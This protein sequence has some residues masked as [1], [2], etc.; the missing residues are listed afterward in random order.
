MVPAGMTMK[1]RPLTTA[2]KAVVFSLMGMS[3]ILP[4]CRVGGYSTP[5]KENERLRA[6][7]NSL[8]AQIGSVTSERDELKVKLENATQLGEAA[9]A[10]PIAVEIEI[11]ALSALAPVDRSKPA[12]SAT[13]RLTP[14]DGRHRFV[15]VTG[16]VTIRIVRESAAPPP[17]TKSAPSTI[18][19]TILGERTITAEQL[20]D[21]FRSGVWGSHYSVEVPFSEP[22][23]R[24]LTPGEQVTVSLDLKESW[25]KR[26][27]HAQRVIEP[28]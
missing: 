5:E 14:L 19:P 28:R 10:L 25:S 20:R 9:E 7:V 2:F 11:D 26:E 13:I 15:P 22:L 6:Q 8:Q 1:K 21:A 16:A 27:L 24:P 4:G 12:T 18:P 17:A 23:A 3:A